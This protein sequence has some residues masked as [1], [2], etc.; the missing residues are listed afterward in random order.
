MTPELPFNG[1][2]EYI[3]TPL[4]ADQRSLVLVKR[5]FLEQESPAAQPFALLMHK[6]TGREY[7]EGE[8]LL[9]WKQL[10]KH[11]NQLQQK[12]GRIVGIQTATVDYFDYQAPG[13]LK[14]LYPG[15]LFDRQPATETGFGEV[16]IPDY[17][18]EKL[19]EEMLRSKRYKHALSVIMI[20]LDNFLQLQ[21]TLTNNTPRPHTLSL[22]EPPIAA[23]SYQTTSADK[24]LALIVQIIKKITRNVDFLSR[25]TGDRFLLILPNTN[26]REAK[27]LAERI[28]IQIFERTGKFKKLTSGITATLAV[29]Q[30][31]ATDTSIDFIRKLERLLTE[32]KKRAKNS[33]YL[34]H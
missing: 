11:K 21:N 6:L 8:A 26:L 17:R 10:I 25:L 3:Q 12:L 15:V 31:S 34:T 29:S 7:S 22:R 28:R 13:E 24:I 2:Q 16:K 27:E 14:L 32:G 19:K 4:S 20:D 30:C 1:F 23:P 5:L 33:V 9:C 18:L